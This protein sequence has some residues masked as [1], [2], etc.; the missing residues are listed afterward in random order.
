MCGI[1][2]VLRYGKLGDKQNRQ[3]ALYLATT[4]LEVTES[5][6]KDATGVAAL[7]DDGNFFGQKMAVRASEFVA[8]FGGEDGD[9]DGLQSVLREY[10]GSSLRAIIGHCRKKSVG[11][12]FDNVNNHPIKAGNII[13]LH[14]GTLKNHDLIFEKL[15]CDRDGTVDSEAIFRLMQ[16][17][18]KNCQE[19]FTLDMLEEVTKR[20]EGSFSI[21]AFNANNPN[22]IVSARDTR[23]AEFCFIKPLNMVLVASE[24]KFIETAIW[25]YN[26]LAWNHGIEWATKLKSS[27]VEIITLK[28]DT[29]ALFDLTHEIG[30][31]TKIT[32]LYTTRDIPKT[33]DR[34][35]KVPVKTTTY[36][37]GYQ[38]RNNRNN[39]ASKTH[40]AGTKAAD[41]KEDKK[42]GTQQSTSTNTGTQQTS[43][44]TKSKAKDDKAKDGLVWNDNLQKYVRHF[45]NMTKNQGHTVVDTEK[46]LTMSPAEAFDS[47]KKDVDEVN[48]DVD[49]DADG[50][51]VDKMPVENYRTNRSIPVNEITPVEPEAEEEDIKTN[52]KELPKSTTLSA[53]KENAK[54][55][56]KD[57]VN[58][59][60]AAVL[61]KNELKKFA[62]DEEVANICDTDVK[63]LENLPIVALANRLLIAHFSKIFT[64]GYL[65]RCEELNNNTQEKRFSRSQRHIRTLKGVTALM[66]GV[67]LE[68]VSEDTVG[69][70]F[71]TWADSKLLGEVTAKNLKEIFNAGDLR[72]NK[73]VRSMVSA[74]DN[75]TD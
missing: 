49:D 54:S 8:R 13:G 53:I 55:V 62:S 24:K 31:D 46:K 28:D 38:G 27:D 45:G 56:P 59:D 19:P 15:K 12:A 69:D 57:E 11:G 3:S 22:Q 52:D 67:V 43:Q 47:V 9:F 21:L 34:L 35:W 63:S 68:E 74:L 40:T 64:A 37:T 65:T 50:L 5:R 70:L 1:V 30:K 17:Y 26:K 73:V 6:G 42:P 25:E 71:K 36:N 14:N 72:A 41:D 60:K 20:L 4:L 39:T 2:G 16:Y 61:A 75:T 51:N 7:F 10:D 18:T 29:I 33:V 66:S 58:A 44:D 23:P 32:D 48:T